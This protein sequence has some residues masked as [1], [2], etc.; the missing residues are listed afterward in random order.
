MRN[1]VLYY[2][3]AIFNAINLLTLDLFNATFYAME[4]KL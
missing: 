1:N 3:N 4:D 2:F